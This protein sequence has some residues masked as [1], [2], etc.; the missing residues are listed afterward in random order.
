MATEKTVG[1]YLEILKNVTIQVGK[2]EKEN[3]II[4]NYHT[5]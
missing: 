3:N 4:P 1:A 2:E 5:Q